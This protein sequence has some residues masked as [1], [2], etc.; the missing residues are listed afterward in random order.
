MAVYK[1]GGVYWY[2]FNF[3]G[4]RIRE[5]SHSSSRR[6]A[7]QIQAARKTQFAKGEVHIDDAPAERMPRFREYAAQVIEKLRAKSKKPAT[8]AFYEAKLKSLLEFSNLADAPLD[9]IGKRLIDEYILFSRRSKTKRIRVSGRATVRY[10]RVSPST[11][12]RELATLRMMLFQAQEDELIE[13]VP[14]IRL[15]DGERQREFVLAPAQEPIYLGAAPQP[16]YDVA[17]LL[18]DTGLRIGEALNLQ[19][20]DIHL[21]PGPDAKFGYVQVQRGK[22][23]NARRTVPLTPRAGSMLVKRQIGAS[24]PWVFAN[25]TGEAP[26]LGTSLNHQHEKVRATLKLPADFVLHSLRHTML[27]RLGLSGADVFT[28]KK[29]AGHSSVKVSERYVHPSSESNERAI[30]RMM[31]EYRHIGG[32]DTVDQDAM[33]AN[34]AGTPHKSPHTGEMAVVAESPNLLQ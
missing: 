22:S 11:V 32:R 24:S 19:W 9:E 14:K 3:K 23:R 25:K 15:L 30:E 5:S 4:E 26:W 31:S 7:E 18:L 12:N 2:E 16:L 34:S 28:I 1:R 6:V 29:I 17:P 10:Y 27:T 33:S 8:I 20:P 13:G 21:S